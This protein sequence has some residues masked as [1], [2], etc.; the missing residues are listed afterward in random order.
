MVLFILYGS[1]FKNK[2]YICVN[3]RLLNYL[4]TKYYEIFD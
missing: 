2:S 1:V 4:K 3:S